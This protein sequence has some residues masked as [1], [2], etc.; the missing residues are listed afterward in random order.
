MKIVYNTPSNYIP[1]RRALFSRLFSLFR[2]ALFLRQ[3][4]LKISGFNA[5]FC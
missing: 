4:V 3:Y 2:C 5:Y 1:S